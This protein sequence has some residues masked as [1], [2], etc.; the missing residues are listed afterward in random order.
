M[1]PGHG[2]LV[3]VSHLSLKRLASTPRFLRYVWMIRRQ[4]LRAEGLIGYTLRARPLARD[5]WTLSVWQNEEALRDFVRTRPHAQVMIAL[6]PAMRAAKFD[7]W[8]IDAAD[9]M[10][11]LPTAISRVA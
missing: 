4:L 7:Q 6:R 5:Y 10:P 1:Q 9:G 3:L 2:Y 8:T 11:S